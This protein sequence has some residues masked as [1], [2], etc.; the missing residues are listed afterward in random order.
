MSYEEL[1]NSLY[2]RPPVLSQR[3]GYTSFGANTYLYG[4]HTG[5]DF[6]RGCGSPIYSPIDFK[7]IRV[8]TNSNSGY[9]N[10]VIGKFKGSDGNWYSVR[11]GH[12]QKVMVTTKEGVRAGSII[13]TEGTTGFSTG[14][15][16]HFEIY[17]GIQNPYEYQHD[18]NAFINAFVDPTKLEE[19]YNMIK[20]EDI[21]KVVDN[22]IR[23]LK[24]EIQG[25][26]E[27][28]VSST[29][30]RARA[31]MQ[32]SVIDVH[33][34]FNTLKEIYQQL[35]LRSPDGNGIRSYLPMILEG[36]ADTV[37]GSIMA[38]EEYRE[39][40]ST[41]LR[42]A[43]NQL[44]GRNFTKEEFTKYAGYPLNEIYEMIASTEEYKNARKSDIELTKNNE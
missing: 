19:I 30:T 36:K 8:D 13:G 3:F 27:S 11:F 12:L 22:S 14:C 24:S 31:M 21:Q 17:R 6:Y 20:L 43:F 40:W 32:D 37:R 29:D 1:G 10:Q 38:S 5:V 39:L 26:V 42:D 2:A 16:L 34:S 28:S 7:A 23:G 35:L 25:M 33:V 9:G 44:L 15:H 18:K 41:R 4:L